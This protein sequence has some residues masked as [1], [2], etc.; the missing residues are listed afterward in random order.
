M[1]KAAF[2]AAGEAHLRLGDVAIVVSLLAVVRGENG[3]KARP[4]NLVS[5]VAEVRTVGPKRRR[6]PLHQARV[7]LVAHRFQ[8]RLCA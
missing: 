6:R 4:D 7:E 1:N 8:R 3:K 2:L 5:L